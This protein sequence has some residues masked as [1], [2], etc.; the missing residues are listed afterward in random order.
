MIQALRIFQQ[1][2]AVVLYFQDELQ[3]IF[4]FS[5]RLLKIMKFLQRAWNSYTYNI[6]KIG[7]PPMIFEA[8]K[9]FS[10]MFKLYYWL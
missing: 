8:L 5:K 6:S 4:W 7:I 1:A 10:K 2:G 9:H 3:K